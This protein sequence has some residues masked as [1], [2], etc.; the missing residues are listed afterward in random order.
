[1]ALAQQHA[2]ARWA[3]S[4]IRPGEKI[5]LD[6]GSTMGALAHEVRGCDKLS[7]T[8]PGI[9]TL[10]ELVDSEDIEV[11]CLVGR[12]RSVSQ[13]SV[14]PLAEAALE[15]MSLDRVFMGADA[16]TAEDGI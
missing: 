5:L 16:V 1:M 3:A 6:A 11:D 10:Q 2:I 12:L 8:T 15:R 14:G 4:M 9:N 7:V 13:S